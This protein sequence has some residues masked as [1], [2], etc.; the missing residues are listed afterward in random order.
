MHPLLQLL[1]FTYINVYRFLQACHHHIFQP[2]RL[3]N[4]QRR[5]PAHQPRYH[6]TG[7]RNLK[8]N[9]SLILRQAFHL[10][11]KSIKEKYSKET[12]AYRR[13]EQAEN[14]IFEYF[15]ELIEELYDE[16]EAVDDQFDIDY[17][18]LK[19]NGIELDLDFDNS[20]K[21]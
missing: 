15:G 4:L 7:A 20:S 17:N 11:I 8:A 1:L 19:L 9:F 10:L 12:E 6:L 16:T 2:L 3:N 5:P 13:K 14:L 18:K 21:K